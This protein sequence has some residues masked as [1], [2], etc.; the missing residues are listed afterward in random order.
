MYLDTIRFYLSDH[1]WGKKKVNIA[2]V[3]DQFFV[4]LPVS[5]VHSF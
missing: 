3:S 2:T 4:Y 1:N 5:F